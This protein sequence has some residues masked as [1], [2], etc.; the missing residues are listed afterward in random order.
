MFFWSPEFILRQFKM[1]CIGPIVYDFTV[2]TCVL[3]TPSSVV[4]FAK[5]L[6]FSL[7]SFLT[8]F[9]F[10]LFFDFSVRQRDQLN[11]FLDYF[12]LLP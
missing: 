6:S 5:S 8:M 10:L 3:L 7:G 1:T 9:G 4:L 12:F 2:L 11:A